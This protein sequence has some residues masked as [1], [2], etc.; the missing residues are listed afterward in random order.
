M[1]HR[2]LYPLEVNPATGEPFLRLPP[3]NE[4]III[5][6][7]RLSD[8]P[9]F[10]PILND[11]RVWQ[12]LEGPP[13][14]YTDDHAA[15]WIKSI[16]EKSQAILQE[17]NAEEI[18]RPGLG[19]LKVV[20]GCPVRHIREVLPDGTDVYL[21]DIS[22]GRALFE[23]I[24]NPEER[25]KQVE[26]NESKAVGDPSIVWMFGD[27][28]APSHH[29]RGVM[30][31]AMKLILYS[32]AIPRMGVRHMLGYTFVGNTASVRVFEKSGFVL[33]GVLDNGKTVRGERRR[34]NYLEWKKYERQ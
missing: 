29:G 23:G 17:L 14:P 3:P 22:I 18:L 28:I 16:T 27:Y 33:R 19:G 11:P 4:N 32:W 25:R 13:I 34:L 20:G 15:E 1:T 26:I 5:T 24:I 30:S 10:V 8:A 21:G 31:A 7:P 9:C 6:P 2:Q 12:W